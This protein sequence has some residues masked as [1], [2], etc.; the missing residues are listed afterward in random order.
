MQPPGVALEDETKPQRTKIRGAALAGSIEVHLEV[1]SEFD[2]PGHLGSPLDFHAVFFIKRPVD[3][4]T[5]E[6]ANADPVVFVVADACKGE[7]SGK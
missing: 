1:G 3:G 5:V 4:L 7:A 2:G 6:V